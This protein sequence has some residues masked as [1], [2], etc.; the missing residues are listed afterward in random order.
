MKNLNYEVT[1]EPYHNNNEYK[2]IELSGGLRCKTEHL[3]GKDDIIYQEYR[4]SSMY[5]AKK[6]YDITNLIHSNVK[7]SFIPKALN[8]GIES[9]KT[10]LITEYKTGKMLSDIRK[11]DKN[12]SIKSISKDL[13]Q[14][15][16]DIHNIK[17]KTKYGW[18]TDN[19]VFK[20]E[21]FCDY[22]KSEL[23]RFE[24][25]IRNV[26]DKKYIDIMLEKGQNCIEKIK[27]IE[28]NLHPQLV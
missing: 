14:C 12:F 2:K 28:N 16:F 1:Q 7:T 5:Q 8:F 15:L 23:L 25:S 4:E 13:A 6:K 26:I 22:L 21:T 9:D 20:H 11:E 17:V 24:D 27:K 19:E 3:T 10:W 18:I